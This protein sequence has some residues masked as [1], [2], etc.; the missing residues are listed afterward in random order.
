MIPPSFMREEDDPIS[1]E[2]RW[3]PS[4]MEGERGRSLRAM[5]CSSFFDGQVGRNLCPKKCLTIS[6]TVMYVG[7]GGGGGGGGGC[8]FKLR[9][10]PGNH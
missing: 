8:I 5:T 3:F 2:S 1:M 10:Q 7:G 4:K 9:D 6:K